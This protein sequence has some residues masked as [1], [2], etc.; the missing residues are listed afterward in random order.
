MIYKIENDLSADLNQ[1]VVMRVL[2]L[3]EGVRF[4]SLEIV[5]H[6][7]RIVQI[8]KREKFRVNRQKESN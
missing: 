2:T 4:G 7:G 5:V 6:D 8:D 3:L 1:E